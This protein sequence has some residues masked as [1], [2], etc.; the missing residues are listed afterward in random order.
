MTVSTI[1]CCENCALPHTT[2]DESAAA[3]AASSA[4][5]DWE[6]KLTEEGTFEY[7]VT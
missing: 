7:S 1:L 3:A 4:D 6:F 2:D 5:D